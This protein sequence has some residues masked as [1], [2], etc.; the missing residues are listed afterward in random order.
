[1]DK[2][3]NGFSE[4]D[5]MPEVQKNL[6]AQEIIV[7]FSEEVER[8]RLT[9]LEV[10]SKLSPGKSLRTALDDILEGQTGALIVVDCPE[11]EG[12]ID[13]GFK[14][15]AKFT[16]QRLAEL[17]KMD[18]AIILSADMQKILL[19]NVLLVPTILRMHS[20]FLPMLPNFAAQR[21]TIAVRHCL[22][23]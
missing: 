2:N 18:G 4:E 7:P 9:F 10:L 6:P 21:P 23:A 11:L 17:A 13:G 20:P 15:N 12:L 16:S 22:P 1:M 3:N 5:V 19:A 8:K 14:I